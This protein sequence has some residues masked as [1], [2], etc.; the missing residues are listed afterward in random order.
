MYHFPRKSQF[1]YLF[2]SLYHEVFIAAIAAIPCMEF[3]P[4][5]VSP[6][7]CWSWHSPGVSAQ[8]LQSMWYINLRIFMLFTFKL[9]NH[10]QCWWIV[11]LA[12]QKFN[13]CCNNRHQSSA[14]NT[15]IMAKVGNKNIS[16]KIF[17]GF[18]LTLPYCCRSAKKQGLNLCRFFCCQPGKDATISSSS[19]AN[20]R[21]GIVWGDETLSKYFLALLRLKR[22]KGLSVNQ[23]YW[24]GLSPSSTGDH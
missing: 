12:S 22:E 18:V 1:H 3:F 4:K 20:K 11:I 14:N 16:P 10:L 19:G 21:G 23:F 8:Y 5:I 9:T 2:Y 7:L 6:W 15:R 24:M 17:F 13:G